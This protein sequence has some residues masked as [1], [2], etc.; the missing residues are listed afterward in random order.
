M[1]FGTFRELVE[2]TEDQRRYFFQLTFGNQAEGYVCIAYLKHTDKKMYTS[3]F[4]YPTQ[5]EE[6]LRSISD[7]C[8]QLVHVYYCPNLYEKP[9]HKDKQYIKTCTNI[10]ADLD[11]CNPQN[12]LHEPTVLIQSSPGRYQAIWALDAPVEPSEAENVSL[13]LHYYHADQGAD[14]SGWDL[15]QLLR[16]PY[17]PNYKYGGLNE[18]PIVGILH[19]NKNKY[20]ISDFDNYPAVE[21]LKFVEEEK[22]I[23]QLPDER[24]ESIVERYAGKLPAHFYNMYHDHPTGD[25]SAALWNLI[26]CCVEAG[27]QRGETFLVAQAAACNKYRRDRRPETELWKDVIRGYVKN[28]ERAKLIPT[29]TATIP[30]LLTDEETRIAQSTETFIERYVDWAKALTDAPTQYHQAGAFIILS[31][32]LSGNV[33]LPTSSGTINANMWFMLLANTTLTRKSTSMNIAMKLLYDVDERALMATDGSIEGILVGMA[34]RPKQPSIFLRDEFSG[35]L[36][37]IAHKDYMAGF[38]EQLTKL[39][40]GDSLKRLLRK[41][42]IDIKDPVFIIYAGG[43]KDKTQM[44]LNEEMVLSGFIPRFVFITADQKPE[45]LRPLGPPLEFDIEHREMIKNELIDLKN[46]YSQDTEITREGKIIGTMH[47]E[48]RATLTPEAWTRYNQYELAL[49]QA[50]HASGLQYLIPVYLRLSVST[51][52]AALLISASRTR[53]QTVTV[54]VSDILHAIY[55][56]QDW[57]IY[58]SEIVNGIGKTYDEKLMEKIYETVLKSNVAVSRG[59]LM[60]MFKLDSKRAEV[61]FNTLT[62]RGWLMK[63]DFSGQTRYNAARVI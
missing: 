39:Y 8:T 51:L 63:M 18:A 34:D 43:V 16:V 23:P 2:S 19:A 5:L 61:I 15:S 28:I 35:L 32:L 56:A 55:Y 44:L 30:K 38:A 7:H 27:M 4:H 57:R 54:E 50:A 31:S 42:T 36:E 12:L 48:F 46:H 47:K 9:G 6:M 3:W 33:V 59:E 52:K 21:A 62:Q 17:T 58:V 29:T 25:W 53:E 14:K 45:A 13:R 49:L 40:D 26:L 10:W 1:T 22:D 37:Q 20:R 11:T 41:E 24:A 60:T